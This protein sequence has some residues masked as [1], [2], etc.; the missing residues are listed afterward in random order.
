MAMALKAFLETRQAIDRRDALPHWPLQSVD[1]LN[2]VLA[3][4]TSPFFVQ[5]KETA[6]FEF[7][8]RD[9]HHFHADASLD[10][11]GLS[12]LA[13]VAPFGQGQQTIV[14]ESVRRAL[15]I[16]AAHLSGVPDLPFDVLRE[17]NLLAPPHK[18][19]VPKLYKMHLY[20]AGGFFSSHVDTA[21]A[22]NHMATLVWALPVQ[23]TGGRLLV[24]HDDE[25]A[26]F[27]SD[28]DP[29]R[30]SWC[31]FYTDCKHRVDPVKSGTRVVLQY[32]LY[33]EDIDDS[34]EARDLFEY[35]KFIVVNE[36]DDALEGRTT[37]RT[38]TKVRASLVPME[39][40]LAVAKAFAL[41]FAE[42]PDVHY[43]GVVLQHKYVQSGLALDLLRGHDA[44][45]FECLHEAFR[46]Q[47]HTVLVVSECDMEY[48]EERKY[49]VF[50]MDPDDITSVQAASR[51]RGAPVPKALREA[52]VVPSSRHIC[53]DLVSSQEYIEHTGNESA[54]ETMIYLGGML[55]VKRPHTVVSSAVAETP[56]TS[57]DAMNESNRM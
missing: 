37:K 10:V 2:T 18:R 35:D 52:V 41:Y 17:I 24:T 55:L 21:H 9:V 36:S 31:A 16:D 11:A 48:A 13:V 1:S 53:L 27:E 3:Q 30:H 50:R 4:L 38:R 34:D 32:D 8:V 28:A 54:P 57:A 15:Q 23:H 19:L 22:A 5:G 49:Q 20:P 33:A 40:R 47:T 43:V 51:G 39:R 44:K 56:T 7:T 12:A 6:T 14:D 42:H 46:C 26:V 29:A 45:L 25:T